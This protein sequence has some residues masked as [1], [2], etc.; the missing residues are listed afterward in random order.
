MVKHIILWKINEKLSEEDKATVCINAK[1]E[2]EGLMG[3]IPGLIEMNVVI[4]A[5]DSSNADMMLDS[6]FGSEDDLAIYR[7]HPEHVR[8][9]DTFVR[10]YTVTRLC[11]DFMV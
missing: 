7:D 10:P 2:L 6:T 1:R 3:K 4:T 11:L 8:V 5:L 9:A